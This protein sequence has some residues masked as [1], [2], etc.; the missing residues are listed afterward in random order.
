MTDTVVIAGRFCGPPQSGN[1][2]YSSGLVAREFEGAV[3]VTLRKPPPLDRALA[4]RRDAVLALCD[5]DEIVAE[6]RPA[7]LELTVPDPPSF[8]DAVVASRTYRG[9]EQHSFP[10]CFVCGPGRA[11]G[12]GLR[13]FPGRASDSRLVA[14]PWVPDASLA[15]PDGCVAPEFLWASLD[16][17][18]YFGAAP[19]ELP[20]ALLGRMTAE[21]TGSVA[22]GERCVVIGWRLGLEGR[23]LHAASALFGADGTLRGK[24]RQT[25]IIVNG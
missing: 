4:L 20:R 6:A 14:A 13:I 23:K 19:E 18:G 24:A 7:T 2:G 5:G 3:E 15:A 1:G 12:D 21:L 10:T 11:A 22:P 25:W 9:F 16:C 8:D 17:P